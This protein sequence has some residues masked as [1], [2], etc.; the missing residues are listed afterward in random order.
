M[1]LGALNHLA[2][3]SAGYTVVS[4]P[5]RVS[6][7]Q[8]V[9]AGRR[10]GPN[11]D[12][13]IE[14]GGPFAGF[15]LTEN[16]APE[17]EVRTVLIAGRFQE[18]DGRV[19]KQGPRPMN[20]MEPSDDFG[21][22]PRMKKIPPGEYRLYL[23]TDG[24][25]TDVT[26]RLHGLRGS[27]KLHPTKQSSA[28]MK[29]LRPNLSLDQGL[30]VSSAGNTYH[31]GPQGL[32][33]VNLFLS[34]EEFKGIEL[35]ACLY[36]VPTAPPSEV[37]YG[38]HC[39]ALMESGLVGGYRLTSSPVLTGPGQKVSIHVTVLFDYVEGSLPNIDDRHGGGLWYAST[40]TID[41]ATAQFAYVT[42]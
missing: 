3:D 39:S 1:A 14:G 17:Q 23:V 19:C 30:S 36:S 32:V 7:D 11:P 33:L 2:G 18:C 41:H 16:P 10:S 8:R 28:D 24:A 21:R 31:L 15:I 6:I 34:A 9:L 4:I 27:V 38:P 13:V 35:G 42:Y 20:Y 5:R 37:S 26:F 22:G 12:I 29:P 40:G 25:D